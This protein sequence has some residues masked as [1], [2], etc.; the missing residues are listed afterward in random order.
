[1]LK[2]GASL[3]LGLFLVFIG[4]SAMGAYVIR[5]KNGNEFVTGRYWEEG[6]QVLFETYGGVFGVDR[7][8]IAKILQSDKPM[9]LVPVREDAPEEKL[10]LGAG[11]GKA[12]KKEANKA[13]APEEAKSAEKSADDPIQREFNSLKAQSDDISTMLTTELSEHLKRLAALK[14]KIQLERK[15]NQYIREYTDLINMGDAAEAALRS[16]R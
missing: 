6:G 3:L 7:F 8:F 1:M 11:T 5:L 15:I 16:R 14:N 10:K 2:L 4:D 9:L 13:S 12:E